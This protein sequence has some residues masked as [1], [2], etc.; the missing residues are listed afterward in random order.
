MKH[1]PQNYRLTKCL[2]RENFRTIFKSRAKK[3]LWTP[4]LKH[5]FFKAF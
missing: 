1:F 2:G 5:G 3:Y 4:V